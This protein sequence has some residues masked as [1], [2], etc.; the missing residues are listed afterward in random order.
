MT[1]LSSRSGGDL[2]Q[3]AAGPL[4]LMLTALVEADPL[5]ALLVDLDAVVA[6][7][8]AAVT[9]LMAGYAAA[10]EWGTVYRVQGSHDPVRCVLDDA[11]VLDVLDVLADSDDLAALLVAVLRLP[12][13]D[14]P[15]RTR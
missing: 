6:L 5:D 1:V 7:D 4:R 12:Y 10:V 13:P 2:R 3:T 15:Q 14:D 9:A 8:V 11:G